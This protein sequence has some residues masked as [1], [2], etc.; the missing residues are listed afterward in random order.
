[1]VAAKGRKLP[2]VQLRCE[3]CRTTAEEAALGWRALHSS[4]PDD[5]L[6]PVLVVF[7]CRACAEVE[8]GPLRPRG[9]RRE[10]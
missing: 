10:A 5:P 3:E 7:Y 2:P 8:F 4:D 1:V 6:E 9:S